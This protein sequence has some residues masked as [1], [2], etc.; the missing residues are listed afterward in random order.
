MK[1][2][3]I[4]QKRLAAL[5]DGA[6]WAAECSKGF[7]KLPR[8]M[9]RKEQAESACWW[10]ANAIRIANEATATPAGLGSPLRAAHPAGKPFVCV[11]GAK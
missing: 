8:G 11:G 4:R 7:V 3:E 5:M 9:T 1:T 2:E 10:V 6:M